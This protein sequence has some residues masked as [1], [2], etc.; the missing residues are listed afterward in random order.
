[1]TNLSVTRRSALKKTEQWLC[2]RSRPRFH[3]LLIVLATGAL[4][5]LCSVIL[6]HLGCSAM[7][8]RYPL[9]VGLAYLAFLGF[10]RLW[11][12]YYATDS[13][14]LIS[15]D[16]YTSADGILDAADLTTNV[17]PDVASGTDTASDALGVF[18]WDELTF[19]LI[20]AA[21]IFAGL[22]VCLYVIWTAPALLAELLVDSVV[23]ASL[24]RRMRLARDSFWA[25]GA[26]RRTWFAAVLLA[27]FFALAGF[28]FHQIDP[29][30]KSIGPVIHQLCGRKR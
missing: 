10:L 24:Y 19:V 9:A 14:S 16:D 23:M 20:A 22:L 15:R 1:M 5:F 12:H 4:G 8:L 28:A 26:L 11:L 7:Y 30:A 18:D 13:P 17:I 29:Q 21:A 25:V 6:L 2:A 27:G 3:M